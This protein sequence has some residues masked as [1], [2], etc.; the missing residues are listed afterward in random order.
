MYY[1]AVQWLLG[2]DALLS[3]VIGAIR[4]RGSIGIV[5]LPGLEGRWDGPADSLRFIFLDLASTSDSLYKQEKLLPRRCN[6]THGAVL[7]YI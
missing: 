6:A 4:L 2:C 5:G 3:R 1:I 7:V